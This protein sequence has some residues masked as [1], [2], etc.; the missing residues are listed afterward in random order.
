MSKEQL[1]EL[2][3]RIPGNPVVKIFDPN[4]GQDEPVTGCTY[5]LREMRLYADEE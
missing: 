3:Q 2:L 5:D 1:I 4:S